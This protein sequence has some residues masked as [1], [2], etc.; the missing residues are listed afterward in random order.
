MQLT[1]GLNNKLKT[2]WGASTSEELKITDDDVA[3]Y[4]EYVPLDDDAESSLFGDHT[5]TRTF[6]EYGRNGTGDWNVFITAWT[7]SIGGNRIVDLNQ[8][9]GNQGTIDISFDPNSGISYD[10]FRP[11]IQD[12]Y[13]FR[14]TFK[15]TYE[16]TTTSDTDIT[17]VT[18]FESIK[19]P[20]NTSSANSSNYTTNHDY[21]EFNGKEL[22]VSS[23]TSSWYEFIQKPGVNQFSAVFSS[24]SNAGTN[25]NTSTSQSAE[26]S[27]SVVP[28]IKIN[29]LVYET[30][31]YGYSG[32]AATDTSVRTVLYG[33]A[34]FT[35]DGT[36]SGESGYS[37]RN[38]PTASR[39]ASHSVSD[40]E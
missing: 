36:G 1:T 4:A 20:F 2:D 28:P 37:W 29:D 39:Y 31:T 13:Q 23:Y 22:L 14:I 21:T 27:M 25:L 17:E 24:Q 9:I 11:G 30:E 15:A 34:H 40:L 16:T 5:R 10:V 8:T 6:S 7:G 38:H 33:D 19:I 18:D 32:E 3:Q 26:V 12:E 35:N